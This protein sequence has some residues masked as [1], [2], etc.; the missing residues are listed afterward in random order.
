[1]YHLQGALGFLKRGRYWS[2]STNFLGLMY[3]M[4]TVLGQG[5]GENEVMLIEEYKAAVLENEK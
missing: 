4:V 3:S 5:G 1:M 2:K